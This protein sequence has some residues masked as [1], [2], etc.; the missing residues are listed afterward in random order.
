MEIATESLAPLD[1]P[2]L[3]STL[4]HVSDAIVAVDSEGKVRF[5]NHAAESLLACAATHVTGAPSERL[6][7]WSHETTGQ[8]LADPL[9]ASLATGAPALIAEG[10]CMR[11]QDGRERLIAGTAV[12]VRSPAGAVSGAVLIFRDLAPVRRMEEQLCQAQKSEALGSLRGGVTHDFNNLMTV[13]LGF[14]E[15]MLDRIKKAPLPTDLQNPLSE[16]KRAAEKAAILTQQIQVLGRSQV[17][18][19][20]VVELNDVIASLEKMLRRT[21]GESIRIALHLDPKLPLVQLDPIQIQQV[22][23]HLAVN[24]R[25]AMPS[26]GELVLATRR[27]EPGPAGAGLTVEL[28]VC[29]TGIGMDTVTLERAFEPCFSTKESGRGMGLPVARKILRQWGGAISLQSAPGHGTTVTITL[30]ASSVQP[31]PAVSTV[32]RPRAA[33]TETVLLVEDAD[34]VRGLLARMLKDAGYKVLEAANGRMGFE[35]C[36]QHEGQIDLLVTDVIMP[37]MTG[38]ELAQ[39]LEQ[40]QRRPRVL[41]LSGHT[42]DDLFRQGFNQGKYHFLQ[43][44]FIGETLLKKVHE[45]LSAP[46]G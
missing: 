20:A 11:R 7:R 13:I 24:A 46:A 33:P 28:T 9:S 42:G 44:P 4:D 25:E 38:V 41:F 35:L 27:L 2:W 23:L 40:L 15:M 37:E 1:N 32:Q 16:I 31:G 12:P 43:K 3:L 6:M 10:A 34:R 30:P 19:V 18:Q 39:A 14:S 26:G 29:D 17:A 22:L 36:R 21:L 5:V 8:P 45:V